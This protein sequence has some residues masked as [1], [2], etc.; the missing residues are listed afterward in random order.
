MTQVFEFKPKAKIAQE[1]AEAEK[2]AL[3]KEM[4]RAVLTAI[5]EMILKPMKNGDLGGVAVFTIPKPGSVGKSCVEHMS[6]GVLDDPFK[7]MG[8]LD[9]AKT[10]LSLMVVAQEAMNAANGKNE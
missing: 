10:Q 4:R 5:R 2:A 7:M 3:E 8:L 1:S 9:H 6:E